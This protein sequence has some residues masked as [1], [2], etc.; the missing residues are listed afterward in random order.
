MRA[1]DAIEERTDVSTYVTSLLTLVATAAQSF[2]ARQRAYVLDVDAA[3]LIAVVLAARS[4][5]LA[6]LRTT[7]V[8][9][10]AGQIPAGNL[11]IHVA[12][13]ALDLRAQVALG[14]IAGMTR[15]LAG[16]RIA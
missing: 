8:V 12:A 2:R 7:R 6:T 13:T 15:H 1:R 14:T 5:L 11:A 10:L 3:Q 4:L 16:V 9:G